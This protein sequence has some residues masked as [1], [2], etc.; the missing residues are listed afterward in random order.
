MAATPIVKSAARVLEVLE[1]FA[2]THV[3]ATVAE[4]SRKLGFPQSSTSKLLSSL[5]RLGYLQHD[6]ETRTYR[7]TLR[8]MFLGAWLHDDLFGEGSI[9]SAMDALRRRTGHTVLV[10]MRQGSQVRIILVLRGLRSDAV[11]LATGTVASLVT[12]AV[13][14]A[15]LAG[16]VEDQLGRILRRANAEERD[17]RRRV[18]LPTLL[19]QIRTT[20]QRG[21]AC[22]ASAALPGR[23][24]VAVPL[25]RFPGQP[26][27]AIGLGA[28]QS[29]LEVEQ[30]QLGAMLIKAATDIGRRVG[31]QGLGGTGPAR[32]RRMHHSVG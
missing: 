26:E 1:H 6:A 13:G 4:M 21:W 18:A 8:V 12:S 3:P 7:P 14:H 28:S 5:E 25:P 23:G 27:F 32:K 20:R 31:A 29:R 9:V 17:A 22:R 24:V 10:G 11:Q 16:D 30:E 19:D 15:L 2:V